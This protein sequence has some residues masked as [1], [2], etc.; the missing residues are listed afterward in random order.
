[1]RAIFVA[2][3]GAIGDAPGGLQICSHEYLRTLGAAG[4]ATTV[5][6]VPPSTPGLAARLRRRVAPRPYGVQWG[7]DFP[8]AVAHAARDAAFVFL[9]AVDLAPL[10]PALK[11]LL[12]DGCRLVLLSHGLESVDALHA[13][14]I[15]A[16]AGVPRRRP[17]EGLLGWLIDEEARQRTFFD[18]VV[19]LSPFEVEIERWLGARNV[20]WLP[21]TVPDRTPLDWQPAHH[22]LGFV[23]TMDHPPT[24]DGLWRFLEALE[25]IAPPDLEVRLVGGPVQAGAAFAR[26]FRF[27]RYLGALPG[28]A[29]EAEAATWGCFVHPLFCYARGC[30]T[31]LA[32]A[33]AW[34]VPI[35][36]TTPGRRGYEWRDGT[37]PVADAPADLAALAL[38]MLEPEAGAEAR[39]RIGDVARSAPTLDE[40]AGRLAA[41]LEIVPAG[42]RRA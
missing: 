23:G 4:L 1:M 22:R 37:L 31:K 27:A 24:T 41:A 26:R 39:R 28:A 8:A 34:G 13:R 33:L 10:A 7:A 3:P 38:R 30:S 36:T 17:G 20:S 16:R 25:P 40:V 9:N 2:H 15:E 19:C 11:P 18:A 32:V 29:L 35:V 6:I 5:M 21:R 12:P 14:R 42:V